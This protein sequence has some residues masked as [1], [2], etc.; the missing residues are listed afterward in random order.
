MTHFTVS[1]VISVKTKFSIIFRSFINLNETLQNFG[2]KN[3]FNAN[4]AD[5]T[6]INGG[7]DL[8]LTAFSQINDITIE[9]K[10]SHRQARQEEQE[11]HQESHES[12]ESHHQILKFERQFL[13]AI[14]HNPS[15]MVTYLGRYYE[16]P[17]AHHD[18]HPQH[19][20]HHHENHMHS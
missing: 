11:S 3:A 19:H 9:H 6:G 10:R 16:P 8:Y 15:G 4:K 13:Y 1:E 12:H 17:E 5:F 20:D 7:N 18:H 2:M 14:R